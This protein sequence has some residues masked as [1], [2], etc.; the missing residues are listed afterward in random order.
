M[1]SA[2]APE[3]CKAVLNAS[4]PIAEFREWI[5]DGVLRSTFLDRRLEAVEQAVETKPP[6]VGEL[7]A[8]LVA[9]NVL[10]EDELLKILVS[11]HVYKHAQTERTVFRGRGSTSC[12]TRA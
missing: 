10:V 12:R 11:E 5:Q 2:I 1:A 9:K 6:M 3:R 8:S 7:Q 4:G